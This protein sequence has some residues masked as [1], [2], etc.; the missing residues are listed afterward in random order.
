MGVIPDSF[1]VENMPL[2]AVTEDKV[3]VSV[4]SLQNVIIGSSYA[5]MK[6]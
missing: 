5:T 1:C 6:V 3:L 2:S 4:V